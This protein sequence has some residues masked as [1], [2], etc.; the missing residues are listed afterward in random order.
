[1]NEADDLDAVPVPK[2]RFAEPGAGYEFAIQ[3]DRHRLRMLIEAPK[4]IKHGGA[5]ARGSQFP[6]LAVDP[7]S[8]HRIH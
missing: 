5:G 7:E 1:L 3:L 2:R 8:Q 4:Q 6:L